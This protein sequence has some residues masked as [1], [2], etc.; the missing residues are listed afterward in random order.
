M[1]SISILRGILA[2]VGNNQTSQSKRV[3]IHLGLKREDASVVF[4]ECS[5]KAGKGELCNHSRSIMTLLC[6]YRLD[7]LKEVP[8]N[9]SVTSRIQQWHRPRGFIRIFHSANKFFYHILFE[10]ISAHW[11]N[12]YYWTQ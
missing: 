5:C 8:E 6:H 9:V 3:I 11:M 1:T 12:N 10:N 2:S 4:A 7:N